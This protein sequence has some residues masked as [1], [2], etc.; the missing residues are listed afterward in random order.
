MFKPDAWFANLEK[1]WWQPPD[2][3][4]PV[5]WL[6]LYLLNAIAGWLVWQETGLE[7]LGG[8]AMLIYGVGLM[9]NA[10]WSAL[11][12]G[13]RRMDWATYDAALLWLLVAL[14]IGVFYII[15]PTAG[16]ITLP[17]LL[18]VSVAFWLSRTVWKLNPEA[19]S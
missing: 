13:M 5:V 12:F 17:Y 10:G 1:P 15:V 2:W 7:R 19:M 18:W 8:L 4:F 14:Q 11:F 6:V 16:L 3:A 9:A